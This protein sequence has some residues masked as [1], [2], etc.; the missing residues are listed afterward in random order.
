MFEVP[1]IEMRSY[2]LPVRRLSG[3]VKGGMWYS[4]HHRSSLQVPP[5]APEAL[6]QGR[7]A[8][9][10]AGEY[11]FIFKSPASQNLTLHPRNHVS[12]DPRRVSR[13]PSSLR[14][15]S[16]A[17]LGDQTSHSTH[18]RPLISTAAHLPSSATFGL[19]YRR[20][21]L[22]T[23]PQKETGSHFWRSQATVSK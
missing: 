10:T 11:S 8:R 5:G 21:K 7:W 15:T 12:G 3:W 13:R 20:R 17:F 19:S 4:P 18:F 6:T 14:L 23:A 1:R 2:L 9:G 22:I 16:R